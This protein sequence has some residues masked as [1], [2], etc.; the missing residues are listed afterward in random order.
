[1]QDFV[2]I[3]FQS[4]PVFRTAV[5]FKSSSKEPPPMADGDI[6]SEDATVFLD[7]TPFEFSACQICIIPECKRRSTS[8][9]QLRCPLDWLV[10]Q[11]AATGIVT[12]KRAVALQTG[13]P[14]RASL[15]SVINVS[16]ARL[17]K[18]LCYRYSCPTKNA[19][20]PNQ[21]AHLLRA[22][23]TSSERFDAVV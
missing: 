4:G 2:E 15:G 3:D 20:R 18:S 7:A 1:V 6:V 22:G 13:Y 8:T 16:I 21:L 14:A 11:F 10:C 5:A 19:S 17:S 9:L 23:K 12:A